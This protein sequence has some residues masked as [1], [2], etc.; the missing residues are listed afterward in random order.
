MQQIIV[1]SIKLSYE[2]VCAVIVV[3]RGWLLVIF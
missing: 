3:I 2:M 1:K